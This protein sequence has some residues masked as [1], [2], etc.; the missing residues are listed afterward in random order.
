MQAYAMDD[1]AVIDH[2]S[3]LVAICHDGEA[4]YRSAAQQ[5]T[6]PQAR[7]LFAGVAKERSRS[8]SALASLGSPHNNVVHPPGPCGHHGA[9]M[10]STATPG[11]GALLPHLLQVE[12]HALVTF[13][14]ALAYDL[15]IDIRS[16]VEEHYR[17]VRRAY[18]QLVTLV[19]LTS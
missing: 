15:P 4:A 1:D 6:D 13:S 12:E 5:A 16:V 2:L 11:D 19:S 14:K 3:Q 9:E 10:R 7:T 17:G 18:G 8:M